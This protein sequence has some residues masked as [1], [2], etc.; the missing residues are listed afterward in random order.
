MAATLLQWPCYNDPAD[1]AT[2]KP[3]PL[4]FPAPEPATPAS[5]ARLSSARKRLRAALA[6]LDQAL[7]LHAERMQEQADQA[8][9]FSAMQEDRSRLAQEIDAATA[10]LRALE[11]ASGE[12]LLRV[13]RAGAAVRAVLAADSSARRNLMAQAVVT[14]AGRTYRMNCDEG[15]EAHI[16]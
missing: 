6:D 8:A 4:S 11:T 1:S 13:E 5:E 15:E 14:I 9:E 7:S 10:R 16:E 3:P 12:A 2:R